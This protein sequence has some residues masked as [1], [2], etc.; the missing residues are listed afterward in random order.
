MNTLVLT[1]AQESAIKCAFVDLVA[2]YNS[3][4]QMDV[5]SH[6]WD[7][8]LDTID[9]LRTVFPFIEELKNNMDISIAE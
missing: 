3:Y 5:H 2:S 6:D 8:H 4:K 1:S 7:S 9:D